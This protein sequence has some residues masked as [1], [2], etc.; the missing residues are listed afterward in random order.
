MNR[1]LNAISRFCIPTQF[2]I[3]FLMFFCAFM[4]WQAPA[5]EVAPPEWI[6]PDGLSGKLVIVGGG[7]IPRPAA[8]EFFRAVGEDGMVV[9]IAAAS[10]NPIESGRGAATWLIDEGVKNV[11]L[12]E[13]VTE[14]CSVNKS[15]QSE[16]S[17]AKGVWICGGQQSR[18]ANAYQGT[19]VEAALRKLLARGGVIGGTSAGAAIM[20]RVMIESGNH[21]PVIAKGIDLLPGA[22][23]DQHFTQRQR[24]ARLRR[25]V[26]DND[27]CFGIGIDEGTAVIATGRTLKIVGKGA[28]TLVRANPLCRATSEQLLHAGDELD[29]TQLRRAT[30]MHSFGLGP[31]SGNFGVRRVV[32]GSL[33]IV[34]GGAISKSIADKF[35]ELAGGESARL[36]V[37]P[38][39]GSRKQAREAKVPTFLTTAR[40]AEAK[41]LPHSRPEEIESEEFQQALKSATGIWFGGGRQ[42]N[43]VDAYEGT[44]AIEL[45][46]DCLRR[47]GVIGGSSAGATIQGEYLVRGHPF[48]NSIMMAPGYE[49]GFAFLPG[50]AIDQ[51]FTQRSRQPDLLPVIRRYPDLLGIGIDEATALVVR[52]SSAE[53]IGEH[54][55]H[56]LTAQQLNRRAHSP[57]MYKENAHESYLTVRAGN[58]IDLG[59]LKI[60]GR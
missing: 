20:T 15:L 38:T 42:W 60:E 52:G 57:Q 13:I 25:A 55:V 18:L 3:A 1:L 45:F 32:A 7:K 31:E 16:I 53:V 54:A 5:A 22:I 8:E 9:V 58:Q 12:P 34:G 49:R 35:V 59:T 40:V 27:L 11:V 4:I 36:V 56:F 44:S 10:A 37:L 46:R 39:A 29:L 23:V 47:G 17:K 26:L 28:V 41:L 19:D 6:D 48:G 43:F 50:T 24:I 30:L 21:T 14:P 2:P 51:H 33:V